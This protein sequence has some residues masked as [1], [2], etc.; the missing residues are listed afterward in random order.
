MWYLVSDPVVSPYVKV[1]FYLIGF[2]VLVPLL[3][4]YFIFAYLSLPT[5]LGR[6]A[7]FP[8]AAFRTLRG[9]PF[10]REWRRLA[11]ST[12]PF[13]FWCVHVFHYLVGITFFIVFIESIVGHLHWPSSDEFLKVWLPIMTGIVALAAALRKLFSKST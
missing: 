9:A 2:C 3:I 7:T 13:F 6:L 12:A 10:C 1:A 11:E 5:Y 4:L 8:I